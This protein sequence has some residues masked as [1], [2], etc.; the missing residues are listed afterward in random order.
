MSSFSQRC[1]M[2]DH[3]IPRYVPNLGLFSEGTHGDQVGFPG[4]K[5]RGDGYCSYTGQQAW[6]HSGRHGIQSLSNTRNPGILFVLAL[7]NFPLFSPHGTSSRVQ[8]HTHPHTVSHVP[9]RSFCVGTYHLVFLKFSSFSI[10]I[11]FFTF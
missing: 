10:P 8:A 11:F 9:S 3:F 6:A 2:L 7:V 4:W 5:L 1:I